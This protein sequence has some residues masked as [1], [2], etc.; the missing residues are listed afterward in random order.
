[1]TIEPRPNVSKEEP[2]SANG[3]KALTFNFEALTTLLDL[4]LGSL[5]HGVFH[6]LNDHH[7]LEV[8]HLG[9]QQTDLRSITCPQFRK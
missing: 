6:L 7:S 8:G 1:M 9:R 5:L 2:T 3:A 4:V